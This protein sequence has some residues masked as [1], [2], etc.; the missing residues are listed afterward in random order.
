MP[1]GLPSTRPSRQPTPKSAKS[2]VP[3]G[4]A[5]KTGG[6]AGPLP[7]KL[8][9]LKTRGTPNKRNAAPKLPG[10]G[11]SGIPGATDITPPS[12]IGS[13]GG[14]PPGSLPSFTAPPRPM[15][16]PNMGLGNAAKPKMTLAQD[17]KLDRKAGIKE[18]S[19]KDN[20]LD[21]KRGVSTKKT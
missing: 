20:A 1:T 8:G 5:P 4:L 11:S 15:N 7:R 21:R 13:V 9:A 3:K 19:K 6:Q 2:A 16:M 12:P 17:R 18:G 10:F 14:G